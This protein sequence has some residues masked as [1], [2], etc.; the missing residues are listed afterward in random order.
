M[1]MVNRRQLSNYPIP[2]A[3]RDLGYDTNKNHADHEQWILTDGSSVITDENGSLLSDP[4]ICRDML[5]SDPNRFIIGSDSATN[6]YAVF[7]SDT[8]D[9][10]GSCRKAPLR[11]LYGV[12][13]DH[14]LGI[15]SRAA[16]LVTFYRT[17][18]YCGTCGEKTRKKEDEHAVVCTAC[19]HI[20]YPVINPV[21]IVC[22]ARGNEILLARSPHFLSGIYSI[23]AG[24]VEA[25]ETL[26]HAVA[27][28]VAEE[29]GVTIDSIR[30]RCSQPWPF[31]HS[32]MIGFTASYAGGEIKIDP[33]EIEDA[34]W[35]VSDNLPPLPASGSISR[36]LIDMVVDEIH[37]GS[38]S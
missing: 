24:F 17:H 32:L 22:I 12:I 5:G 19:D 15:A 36:I 13:P 8:A 29:V 21:I 16:S 31:P 30:Y 27:R 4:V 2:F 33:G 18:Q 23:I 26:E 7:I 34:G 6:W 28:E 14:I 9:L 1:Y 38:L 11:S 35:Y 10:P 25:G 20:F 3:I 37:N